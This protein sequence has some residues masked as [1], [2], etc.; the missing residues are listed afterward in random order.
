MPRAKCEQ[1]IEHRITIGNKER[2]AL[3]A[4]KTKQ[5]MTGYAYGTAALGIA[6]ALGVTAYAVYWTL[7][8]LYDWIEGAKD[9]IDNSWKG[10]GVYAWEAVG[11]GEVTG[12]AKKAGKW[13]KS[14]LGF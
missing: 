3:D 5:Q 12:T 8:V 11:G 1:V 13:I 9:A 4:F 2:E 7:D 10:A 14:G 6:A